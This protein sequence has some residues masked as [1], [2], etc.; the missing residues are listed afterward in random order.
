MSLITKIEFINKSD[1]NSLLNEYDIDMHDHLTDQADW[2]SE[3][4][5]FETEYLLQYS[6]S[7]KKIY[8]SSTNGITFQALWAGE[9]ASENIELSLS[10]LLKT[11]ETNKIKTRA[12]YSA[13]KNA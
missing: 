1:N 7:I 13:R 5:D 11:I 4:W 10:E 9:I 2:N 3:Y 12:K 8:N 6:K